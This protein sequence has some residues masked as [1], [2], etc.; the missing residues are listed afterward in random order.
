MSHDLRSAAPRRLPRSGTGPAATV[1]EEETAMART[2]TPE[3]LMRRVFFIVVAGIALQI[4]AFA[5]IG[6]F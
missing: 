2:Y 3:D 1:G 6:L 4:A 5:F